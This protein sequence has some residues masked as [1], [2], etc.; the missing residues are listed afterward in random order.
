MGQTQQETHQAGRVTQQE[1][2]RTEGDQAGGDHGYRKQ[3]EKVWPEVQEE[4][5][6]RWTGTP[7]GRQP[8]TSPALRTGNVVSTQE[9]IGAMNR[10]TLRKSQKE[11]PE[12]K[13]AERKTK[14][15]QTEHSQEGN[16]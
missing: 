1:V 5:A 8:E 16:R 4:T 6:E 7:R 12:I 15:R 2:L 11:M 13:N 14:T 3:G 10:E 9:Q